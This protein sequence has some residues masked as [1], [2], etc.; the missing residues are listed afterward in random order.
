MG[1]KTHIPLFVRRIEELKDSDRYFI[2]Y[3][4][5]SMLEKL[6]Y[7]FSIILAFVITFE[8]CI[9]I[10][11]LGHLIMGKLS[12]YRLVCFRIASLMMSFDHGKLKISKLNIPGT[13]GQ[14]VMM[15][16]ESGT[17]EKVPAVLYHAGGGMFN[18]LSALI[19]LPP[20]F[21]SGNTDLRVFCLMMISCSL[22]LALLNLFPA[23]TNIPNDGYN[24]KLILENV[25]DRIAIYNILS[26]Q[27]REELSPSEIP[28]RFYTYS[29]EGE[30]SR[31]M[32]LM[33]GYR[34][35][36]EEN[37]IEAERFFNEAALDDDLAIPYYRMQAL[38][39]LL[40]CRIM[41]QTPSKEIEAVY[42]EELQQY[43]SR[44]SRTSCASARTLYT[45]VRYAENDLK[46]A[47]RLYERA[48]KVISES[49]FEGER[50]M[51]NKLMEIIKIQPAAD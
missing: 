46:S 18:L 38:S 44:S 9:V 6:L 17:P 22:A 50:K 28:Q 37:F 42:D 16:P 30:Y 7:A 10:H 47:E 43:L 20:L 11:E 13:G 4:G 31:V 51:E 33:N 19:A 49:P 26:I 36:D 34:M 15:P 39:E 24:C 40:F 21:Y 1:Y 29:E 2:Q 45:Y 5:V 32:K 14:C 41:N 8:L 35:L 12:G 27:G 25:N 23:K 48:R 3:K